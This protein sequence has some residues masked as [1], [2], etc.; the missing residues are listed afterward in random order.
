M[1]HFAR[2]N[3][4]TTLDE[5]RHQILATFR[6][7]MERKVSEGFRFTNYYKELPVSYEATLVGMDRD[8]VEFRVHEQQA[9]VLTTEK[10]TFL[11]SSHFAS[12]MQA[13]VQYVNA[14]R[15]AVFLRNFVY[16]TL[17]SEQRRAV[18]VKLDRPPRVDVLVGGKRFN[19]KLLDLSV[20]GAALNIEEGSTIPE[21]SD[22][23]LE[24]HLLSPEDRS[25]LRVDVK[26]CLIKVLTTSSPFR[27][28]F[29][30]QE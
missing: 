23:L 27:Y 30:L 4:Q 20:T 16:V 29:D 5:D 28:V 17:I 19:G 10:E 26:G 3:I 12:D 14:K 25:S 7:L 24:M 15:C 18:R 11:K 21:G 2:T 13:D 1:L 6:D 9:L 22:A 8:L